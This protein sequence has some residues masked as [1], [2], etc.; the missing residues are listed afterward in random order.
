[1]WYLAIVMT[2]SIIFSGAL[3]NVTTAEIRRGIHSESQRIQSQF[4][5][6]NNDPRLMALG[7]DELDAAHRVLIRLILLNILVLLSAGY[8]SYILARKTLEPIELAHEQQKRF[9]SDVSHELRTPLTALRMESE[10]ALLNPHSSQKELRKTIESNL[11]EVTKLDILINNL[12][13]LS[14]LEVEKLQDNF[15]KVHSRKIIEAAVG[16][17]AS[18]AKERDIEIKSDLNDAIVYGDKESLLQV[19]IILLDNAI[20]YS[21]PKQI[22]SLSSS[23]LKEEV[24]WRIEDHGKGIHPDDLKHIFNRFYQ[25]ESSRNKTSQNGYG[26][27]LSIAKMITDIHNGNIVIES[28]VGD[29]TIATIYLPKYID[30]TSTLKQKG[31]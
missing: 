29:G 14:R 21:S 7:P 22:I 5:V 12:L 23:D 13:K 27:G 18:A 20:K 11:E 15:H 4:P 19:L 16:K 31:H 9:T 8:L 10:V 6:F 1:M 3:Y 26:L 24:M 30:E 17:L 25:A 2:I 28:K